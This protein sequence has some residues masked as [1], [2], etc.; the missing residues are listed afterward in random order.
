MTLVA[1]LTT[2]GV[3][4]FL[5]TVLLSAQTIDSRVYTLEQ[6][7]SAAFSRLAAIEARLDNLDQISR[8]VLIAVLVQIVITGVSF[9]MPAR[10]K[11][12]DGD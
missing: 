2:V 9:K 1:R 3:A 6:N 12:R 8:A 7:Q 11:T 10:P 4:L 5:L